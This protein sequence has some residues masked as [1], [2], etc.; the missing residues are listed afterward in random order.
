MSSYKGDVTGLYKK[1]GM[2]NSSTLTALFSALQFFVCRFR[3][4]KTKR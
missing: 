4:E 2:P 1:I 3:K